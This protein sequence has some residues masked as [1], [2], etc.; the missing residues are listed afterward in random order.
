MIVVL[1]HGVTEQQMRNLIA[2]FKDQGVDVHVSRGIY[3]TV[4]GLVGDTSDID[5][6]LLRMLDIVDA[7]KRIT[8]PFKKANRKF[9]PEDSVIEVGESK[10]K[11]GGGN[12]AVIA[13][14]PHLTAVKDIVRLVGKCRFR[15]IGNHKGCSTG[16]VDFAVVMALYNFDVIPLS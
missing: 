7:V 6:D 12:F 14:G 1:K 13:G 11:I 10:V 9:H 15:R 8:D 2:W 3:Q 16:R 5:V 4:L